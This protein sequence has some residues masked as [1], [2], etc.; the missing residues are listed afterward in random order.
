M[1]KIIIIILMLF[2]INASEFNDDGSDQSLSDSDSENHSQ[3]SPNQSLEAQSLLVFFDSRRNHLPAITRSLPIVNIFDDIGADYSFLNP[4]SAANSRI[5][6]IRFLIS[7]SG[8]APLARSLRIYTRQPS[9]EYLPLVEHDPLREN[10]TNEADLNAYLVAQATLI[11]E[12]PVSFLDYITAQFRQQIING[13]SSVTK[14][15]I[16]N[17]LYVSIS[18]NRQ[19]QMPLDE[20]ISLSPDQQAAI[21]IGISALQ[22]FFV[23]RETERLMRLNKNKPPFIDA[24]KSATYKSAELLDSLRFWQER[25]YDQT[26]YN[27]SLELGDTMACPFGEGEQCL[28]SQADCYNFLQMQSVNP[29]SIIQEDKNLLAESEFLTGAQLVSI[30]KR[31]K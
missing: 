16:L 2:L 24:Q 3:N 19:Q 30:I 15:E 29:E 28:I 18:L 31:S 1:K 26:R 5:R 17:W 27:E 8:L 10:I 22:P 25:K 12:D 23:Q 7:A 4:A 13:R 20:D 9:L 6:D 21:D 11:G 14:Q